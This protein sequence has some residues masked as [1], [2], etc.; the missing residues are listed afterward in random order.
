MIDRY[1]DLETAVGSDLDHMVDLLSQRDIL[2]TEHTGRESYLGRISAQV[3]SQ[4]DPARPIHAL[5]IPL[6]I[7]APPFGAAAAADHIAPERIERP[8]VG[9]QQHPAA[10]TLSQPQ[11][12][13]VARLPEP[14]LQRLSLASDPV[15]APKIPVV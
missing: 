4:Y 2:H 11:R 5:T 7:V 3:A 10:L 14:H 8:A 15:I 13:L 1:L 12:P 6:R 9:A